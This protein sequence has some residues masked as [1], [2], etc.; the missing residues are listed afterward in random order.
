MIIVIIV[1]ILILVFLYSSG[2]GKPIA[3]YKTDYLGKIDPQIYKQFYEKLGVNVRVFR[4][5]SLVE[6]LENKPLYLSISE[7]FNKWQP[8]LRTKWS[9]PTNK[10]AV[11]MDLEMHKI[12]VDLEP[13]LNRLFSDDF[14]KMTTARGIT[15]IILD[16]YS[17]FPISG[18][19]VQYEQLDFY[20]DLLK[21][22]KN[23]YN[24]CADF[25]EN[26]IKSVVGDAEITVSFAKYDPGVGIR[27]HF[28]AFMN[29]D[30]DIFAV[31]VG[32]DVYY[33]FIPV[34]ADF[35]SAVRMYFPKNHYVRLYGAS[36]YEWTH[37]IPDGIPGTDNK[38]TILFKC[39]SEKTFSL[40]ETPEYRI[41]DRILWDGRK[42]FRKKTDKFIDFPVCR[43][44]MGTNLLKG[45]FK[46]L[47]SE[48]FTKPAG[49]ICLVADFK[50][51]A[52]YFV[53]RTVAY[54][55]SDAAKVFSENKLKIRD[56]VGTDPEKMLN[57]FNENY[58]HQDIYVWDPYLF[59]VVIKYF[60]YQY[61]LNEFLDWGPGAGSELVAAAACDLKYNYRRSE[62]FIDY[63]TIGMFYGAEMREHV[64]QI[65]GKYDLIVYC[66]YLGNQSVYLEKI[67]MELNRAS[68]F[69]T[70]IG[71]IV[72]FVASEIE[73]PGFDLKAFYYCGNLKIY[74]LAPV[75]KK[76]IKI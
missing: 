54:N 68:D 44:F 76:K 40:T 59:C 6:K 56:I 55:F 15:Q 47:K 71:M 13:E 42:L 7:I 26:K 69:L 70:E 4:K 41:L 58:K 1:F 29:N 25:I 33:D 64:G 8:T 34:L 46:K 73:P 5:K 10:I 50:K 38:Y 28:D 35:G 19:R 22:Y 9:M 74:V 45:I 31:N 32:A 63:R 48:K 52:W 2:G 21:K 24:F 17:I 12:D 14:Y 18:N 57:Y 11:S 67:Y 37:G 23:I 75:S 27:S 72:L 30:L 60:K 39:K 3:F 49:N 43:E 65:E 66:P 51:L 61:G 53:D 20:I 36:R 62:N 16:Y